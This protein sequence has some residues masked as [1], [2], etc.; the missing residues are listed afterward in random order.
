MDLFL[1]S[2]TLPAAPACVT[3]APGSVPP[4]AGEP[5]AGV[6]SP[7]IPF[8]ELLAL[9]CRTLADPR[10]FAAAGG[11]GWVPPDSGP[12]EAAPAEEAAEALVD[13]A[14][15]LP[16][17]LAAAAGITAAAQA[18]AAEGALP[19]GV[20]PEAEPL[21]APA[22]P[23]A[24]AAVEPAAGIPVWMA[25]QPAAV[26]GA[27]AEGA[28]EALP[29]AP[30]GAKRENP[31]VPEKLIAD[32]G[33]APIRLSDAPQPGAESPP[34]TV[35]SKSDGG[36]APTVD[37]APPPAGRIEPPPH[38]EAPGRANAARAAQAESRAAAPEG[39]STGPLQPSARADAAPIVSTAPAPAP[40]PE[41]TA[42]ARPREKARRA[43]TVPGA[44][45]NVFVKALG[46]GESAAPHG[47]KESLDNPLGTPPGG[48]APS[49]GPDNGPVSAAEERFPD[50]RPEA[51]GRDLRLSSADEGRPL[52]PAA[53]LPQRESA[54]QVQ[55]GGIF[56]QIVQRAAL[57]ARDGRTEMRIDL[58]PEALGQ[59]R[60]QIMTE[61]QQV[62]VRIFAEHAGVREIIESHMAQLKS[63]LQQQGLQID[64]L[65]V[66]VAEGERRAPGRQGN[67]GRRR[68][69]APGALRAAA[70][71]ERID[72]AA[73]ALRPAGSGMI[74]T[75]I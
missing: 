34:R 63:D 42:E 21:E 74:D 18:P 6:G 32:Q 47:G 7:I 14:L 27:E 30:P 50:M 26:G 44:A 40:A 1:A 64:R 13:S 10:G 75:F 70:G 58:K 45:R 15:E 3:A 11:E 22:K 25:P 19:C 61:Y 36:P 38:A 66:A 5:A 29:S 73:P 31:S 48:G 71:P 41:Q 51:A 60:L 68:P 17:L 23:I 52:K 56:D 24:A 2:A 46:A 57:L 20:L 62:S 53:A 8:M 59:V 65:E 12:A 72:A 43:E 67:P 49:G 37:L 35:A 69:G 54:P 55:R 33:P 16:T 28:A 39:G 9:A 4:A